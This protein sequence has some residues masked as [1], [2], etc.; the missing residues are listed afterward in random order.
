MSV[1]VVG[2]FMTDLVA[3]TTKQPVA[4]QTV[5]GESFGI[6]LGGK[7]ANQAIASKRCDSET[8]MVGALGNDN[9]G[10][11][12]L[13]FLEKSGFDKNHVLIKEKVSSGV[14][15]IV[16]DDETGQNQIIIIPGA[17][18]HFTEQDLLKFEH[19][20][21]KCNIVVNQLEMQDEIIIKSKELA[22]KY[23]KKYLLNPAPYKML[24]DDVLKD[25]DFLTPNETELAG[26]VGKTNLT[27]I[28]EFKLAAS[29]LVSKGVKNVVV[30]L[31]EKGALHCS[32]SGC[33]LYAAYKVCEVVD[34]V[35][36]GDAFNGTFAAMIDQGRSIEEAIKYANASGAL[37][38]MKK[39]AIPSIPTIKE[40]EVFL[41]QK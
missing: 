21:K 38:V 19:L 16:I 33:K 10:E 20:F 32:K 8:Y 39:G 17:N 29:E 7:G 35:A 23:N 15:H 4:G 30:T 11:A 22:H 28:D 31:G 14:G 34:T 9:F 36:A 13:E 3:R 40:I 25:I 24:S 12:F 26:F 37:T 41:K 27:E 18:L 5:V 6:Y 1:L 2:S